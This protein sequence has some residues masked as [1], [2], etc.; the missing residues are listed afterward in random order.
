M[1]QGH[2]HKRGQKDPQRGQQRARQ[3]TDDI[4]DERSRCKNRAGGKLSDRNSIQ[5]LLIGQPVQILHQV[6]AQKGQQGI[7]AAVNNRSQFEESE[8]EQSQAKRGASREYS[9]ANGGKCN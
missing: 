1:N 8:K 7:A 6:S 9:R 5:E 3:S 2:K 4:A